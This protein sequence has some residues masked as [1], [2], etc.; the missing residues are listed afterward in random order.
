MPSRKRVS[1]LEFSPSLLWGFLPLLLNS[2]YYHVIWTCFL[3]INH[4]IL[5][6]SSHKNKY[7]FRWVTLTPA[8]S[9]C[10]EA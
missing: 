4:K 6:S 3:P 10:T 9:A 2:L 7:L 1:G 5:V 8:Y